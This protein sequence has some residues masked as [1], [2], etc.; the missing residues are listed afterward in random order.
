VLFCRGLLAIKSIPNNKI[1]EV[2]NLVIL[3][4]I[5]PVFLA[6]ILSYVY[7]PVFLIRPLIIC[8]PAF[9]FII[10]SGISLGNKFFLKIIMLFVI[11]I[12]NFISINI[13][14][15]TNGLVDWGKTVSL[16]KQRGIEDNAV[17]IV[18]IQEEIVP[19][20][21]YFSGKDKE[22]L[23]NLSLMGKF[24][25]NKWHDS[26]D[27]EG[28][29]IIGVADEFSKEKKLTYS[30]K[31]SPEHNIY[32]CEY[33]VRELDKK[34]LQKYILTTDRQ[35]WLLLSDWTTVGN[36]CIAGMI[37]SLKE[38]FEIEAVGEVGGVKVFLLKARN[39]R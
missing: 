25:N 12:L 22:A 1:P 20:M 26:F 3:W 29:R 33:M 15:N 9:Y 38:W 35:I 32:S 2:M 16:M 36:E 24:E 17:I 18:C 27:Y 21:Y 5:F 6:F 28:Y 7:F 31:S 37:I 14:Y 8:A 10:A 19:F 11:F 39:R 34:I 30:F 4:L 13:M 23:K